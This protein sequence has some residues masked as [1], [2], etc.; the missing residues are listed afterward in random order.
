MYKSNT[1]AC[2]I[3]Q[4]RTGLIFNILPYIPVIFKGGIWYDRLGLI[5]LHILNLSQDKIHTL[6]N[7]FSLDFKR[8]SPHLKTDC[9]LGT[10]SMDFVR[11]NNRTYKVSWE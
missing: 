5:V 9:T 8:S 2:T 4:V 11:I 1:R 3:L 6:A 7:P 10:T